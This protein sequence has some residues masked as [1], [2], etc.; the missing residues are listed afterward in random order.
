[1]QLLLRPFRDYGS[2]FSPLKTAVFCALFIPAL[3][4]AS[5]YPNGGLGARPLTE[6]LHQF[7]D[8][9]I[10]LIFIALAVTPAAQLLQW[11]RL[12][13]VRRMI[14]VAAFAYVAMHLSLYTADEAW[15][16][17]KV[18]SEILLRVYLAIGIVAWL[19]LAALAAT[20][21]DGM[22]RR[23]GPRRWQA[24]HR[25]VYLIAALAVVHYFLQSKL[26]EWQPTMMAGFY[27]W[28]MGYR[29][30]AA[31][32][33]PARRPALW[34]IGLLGIAAGVATALGE[35]LYFSLALHVPVARILPAEILLDAN[36]RPGMAVLLAGIAVTVI[37]GLRA[38]FP[39]RR[40]PAAARPAV[41][42]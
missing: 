41:S 22:I 15:N 6:A 18:F 34:A 26:Q 10:R 32:F 30:L 27:A 17:A 16:L 14:G 36:M 5:R 31:K 21:T 35:T 9:T 20:S 29:I 4:V 37:A 2:R 28:L 3:W 42:T 24:L 12:L 1:M 11:N 33:R 7:G 8:W 39:A 23:L 25:F 13:L 40:K 19:G 38:L